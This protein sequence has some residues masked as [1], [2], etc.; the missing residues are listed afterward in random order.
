[1]FR[2]TG[3]ALAPWQPR[4]GR[5]SEPERHVWT[6]GRGSDV[7]TRSPNLNMYGEVEA[8]GLDTTNIATNPGTVREVRRHV[9]K[10]PD[11][12]PPPGPGQPTPRTYSQSEKRWRDLACS[13]R[14]I[15]RTR[16]QP[17]PSSS[18]GND[19]APSRLIRIFDP[20]KDPTYDCRPKLYQ[21]TILFTQL[22][23][24]SALNRTNNG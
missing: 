24:R 4:M 20:Q 10:G 14:T 18:A 3:M 15:G 2:R 13:M 12:I 8:L 19:L 7:P 23:Q 1:M 21:P 6:S 17:V 16:T 9:S 5:P 22:R 11:P